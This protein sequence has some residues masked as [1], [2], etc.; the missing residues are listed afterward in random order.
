MARLRRLVVRTSLLVLVL[1]V[2]AFGWKTRDEAHQMVTNPRAT[3]KVAT[4]T[5]AARQ[6]PYEDSVVTTSDGL[7]LSGWFIPS[8]GQPTVMLVHGYKDHRGALLGVA[9]VLHRHGYGVLVASL[10]AHDINDGELISFGLYEVRDLEAWYQYL[11]G[12]PDVNPRTIGLFGSSMGGIVGIRYA[13][14]NA[15]IRAVI[16]DSAF[17]SVTD[18]AATSIKF[19]TGLPAFP[20]APAMI[21]WMERDIGGW[22]SDLDATKWI[23]HISPRAVFLMQGGADT[24]VSVESGRKLYDAAGD[25]KELWFEPGVGHTQFLAKMPAEFETRVIR[26]LDRYLKAG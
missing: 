20:F 12:R 16:A 11:L 14:Q 7:K 21:F 24:V 2:G 5:P 23:G 13:S 19:F 18:T 4:V 22:A 26:F 25:P 10:R 6:L 17:S 15:Q 3:R 8:A 1:A 9:E